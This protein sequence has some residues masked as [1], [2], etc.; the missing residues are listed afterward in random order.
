MKT[1]AWTLL[2]ISH[3][4]RGE[5]DSGTIRNSWENSQSSTCSLKGDWNNSIWLTQKPHYG[6]VDQ[7][8]NRPGALV[9]TEKVALISKE[10]L[11]IG[12]PQLLIPGVPQVSLG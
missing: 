9:S 5:G 7:E 11:V 1:E 8:E 12:P 2:S 6:A 4:R 3:P 10:N